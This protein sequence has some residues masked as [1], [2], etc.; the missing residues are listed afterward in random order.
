MVFKFHRFTFLVWL[1]L[2]YLGS[3]GST[4]PAMVEQRRHLQDRDGGW[5]WCQGRRTNKLQLRSPCRNPSMTKFPY[6]VAT[7]ARTASCRARVFESRC[8]SLLCSSHCPAC[9]LACCTCGK[10]VER[11]T[12]VRKNQ[13]CDR[14][15]N[16]RSSLRCRCQRVT[17][18]SR[19]RQKS[20]RPLRPTTFRP[21]S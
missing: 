5:S 19:R 4:Y 1:I 6:Q 15:T 7:T 21:D 20:S 11:E 12:D 18:T 10:T 13:C 17:G 9:G 3:L 2:A 8:C 14:P 16:R